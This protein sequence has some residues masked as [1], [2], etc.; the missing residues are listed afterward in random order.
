MTVELRRLA[1]A[2]LA[3]EAALN[4]DERARVEAESDDIRSGMDDWQDF[5]DIPP[6]HMAWYSAASPRAVLALL[7]EADRLRRAA[8][9]P[10][11]PAYVHMLTKS[12]RSLRDLSLIHI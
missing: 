7:D 8:A 5:D 3:E 10:T 2:A 1:E 9:K 4:A 6:A 11:A 12:L